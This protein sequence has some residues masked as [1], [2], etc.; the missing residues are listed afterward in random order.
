MRKYRVAGGLERAPL[1]G[2]V[3][4]SMIFDYMSFYGQPYDSVV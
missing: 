3:F 4:G 2:H 1:S